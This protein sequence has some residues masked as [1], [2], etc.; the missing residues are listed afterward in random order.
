MAAYLRSDVVFKGDKY[1]GYYSVNN[2]DSIVWRYKN[3]QEGM[4]FL[5][6]YSYRSFIKDTRYSQVI[7]VL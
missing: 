7:A 4:N 1:P 5:R 6:I 3:Y 2:I